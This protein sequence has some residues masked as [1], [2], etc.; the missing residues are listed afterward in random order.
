VGK[1]IPSEARKQ[2]GALCFSL[3]SIQ[4]FFFDCHFCM[5]NK[6]TNNLNFFPDIIGGDY[7]AIAFLSSFLFIFETPPAPD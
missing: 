5:Q 3:V 4:I 1:I 7:H 2:F 6:K